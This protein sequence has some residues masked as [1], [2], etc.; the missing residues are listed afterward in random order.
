MFK[1]VVIGTGITIDPATLMY[2]NAVRD[3]WENGL[4]EVLNMPHPIDDDDDKWKAISPA[5]NARAI[6]GSLLIQTPENEYLSAVQLFSSLEHANVAVDMYIYP[7]EGHLLTR[8][9]AHQLARMERSIDWFTFWLGGEKSNEF[10][11]ASNMDHWEILRNERAGR[12][13]NQT[14]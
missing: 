14:K 6:V 9:P 2:T 5:L 10:S 4:L 1:T 8:E 3:S 13:L 12:P 11:E 7:N